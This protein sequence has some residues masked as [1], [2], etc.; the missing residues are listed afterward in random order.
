MTCNYTIAEVPLVIHLAMWQKG[1]LAF[2]N[3]N[4][5]HGYLLS[6]ITPIMLSQADQ[7]AFFS[8]KKPL[9]SPN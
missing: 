9:I 7:E 5:N 3:V 2:A 4:Y 6:E 8:E 1:G